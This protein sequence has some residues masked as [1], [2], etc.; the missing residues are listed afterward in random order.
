MKA[1]QQYKHEI[2]I[3]VGKKR[4]TESFFNQLKTVLFILTMKMKTIMAIIL[5]ANSSKCHNF[6]IFFCKTKQ[7]KSCALERINMNNKLKAKPVF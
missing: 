4:Q 7:K 3:S 1:M 2:T 6:Q 5:I